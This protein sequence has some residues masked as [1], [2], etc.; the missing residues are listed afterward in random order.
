[1]TA[2]EF[3]DALA[4]QGRYSFTAPEASR[5]LAVSELATRAAL[6]R[7]R[8]KGRLA[9]P[10]GGF[11]VIVPPEYRALGCLPPDQFVPDLMAH[12]GEPYYVGL[13]SAAQY[14]G[15]AHQRP[16]EFQVVIPVKRRPISCGRARIAFIT[17][18][19]A[20]VVP[21]LSLNTPRSVLQVSTPEATALDLVGYPDRCGGLGNVATVLA[22]LAESLD[23]AELA[24]VAR[25]TSP[26]AWAQRLGHLLE[27]LGA[28]DRCGPLA[29]WVGE[30]A[31]RAT[32]LEP[33]LPMDDAPRDERWRVA[34]NVAVEADL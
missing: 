25:S 3:L 17:R 34:V 2:V 32:P 33:S 5:E 14:H 21:T 11:F 29:A 18:K 28:D 31:K 1:M 23:P 8:E 6:R 26:V 4:A 27:S 7:L 30:A 19:N 13:L 24:R 22:E 10:H 9:T 12:L 15:A 16:Q 20:A